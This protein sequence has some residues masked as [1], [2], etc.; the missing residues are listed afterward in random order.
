MYVGKTIGG[1]RGTEQWCRG[2][3]LLV[4]DHDKA[5]K[6]EVGGK[7]YTPLRALVRLVS[8]HQLGHFM[9]GNARIVL[10]ANESL[11]LTLS[12]D[13]GHDG[14]PINID[15]L[16]EH[17]LV[18]GNVVSSDVPEKASKLW[19][20]LHVLPP[21]L[22]KAFWDGGGH[23]AA[24]SEGPALHA[25]AVKNEAILRGLRDLAKEA[26]AAACKTKPSYST[27]DPKGWCG[28]PRRG[29]ALGRVPL[30]VADVGYTGR[31]TLRHVRLNSGGYDENGTYFGHPNTVYWYANGEGTIDCTLRA[32]N[33]AAARAAVLAVYPKAQVRR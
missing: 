17:L 32:P 16:R 4:F 20:R 15:T 6:V 9:M 23:N 7:E 25:W 1:Y 10:G 3:F 11:K 21:L 5:T 18:N 28:D 27:R 22:V 26:R 2:P 14:L 31:I 13:Y 30:K 29:A 8:L 19:D 12:G 33:R 24:G